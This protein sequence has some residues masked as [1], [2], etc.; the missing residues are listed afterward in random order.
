MDQIDQSIKRRARWVG[1]DLDLVL[2]EESEALEEEGGEAGEEEDALVED[3]GDDG[4]QL[5]LAEVGDQPLHSLIPTARPETA[6]ERERRDPS[7][8]ARIAGRGDRDRNDG[9]VPPRRS[10]AGWP[11]LLGGRRRM[12]GGGG[13]RGKESFS[14]LYVVSG[15]LAALGA[16][17]LR[18]LC[19]LL[20]EYICV[21]CV[22]RSSHTPG[23]DASTCVWLSAPF[24]S[25]PFRFLTNFAPSV[26]KYNF[27]NIF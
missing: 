18:L 23:L 19:F 15:W 16:F 6:T 4:G 22:T 26:S 2:G 17:L 10:R 24:A 3:E 13:G 7:R 14:V 20:A 27:L 1:A 11:P 5:E 8:S 25:L 9:R 21:L 12:A